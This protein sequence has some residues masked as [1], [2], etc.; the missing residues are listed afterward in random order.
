M[1]LW[2]ICRG[3]YGVGMNVVYDEMFGYMFRGVFDMETVF[4]S[5]EE[6]FKEEH[7]K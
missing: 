3:R 1:C 6:F 2:S 5:G 7:G 4:R